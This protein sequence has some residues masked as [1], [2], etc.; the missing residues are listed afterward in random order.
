M[1]VMIPAIIGVGHSV[2]PAFSDLTNNSW[3]GFGVGKAYSGTSSEIG[4]CFTTLPS[5]AANYFVTG[6]SF[7]LDAP[8]GNP[9]GGVVEAIFYSQT[10]GSV[11]SSSCTPS[12]S[13]FEITAKQS[14]TLNAG[15]LNFTFP[16]P[17]AISAGQVYAI[18][19]RLTACTFCGNHIPLHPFTDYWTVATDNGNGPAGSELV[20]CCAGGPGIWSQQPAASGV[21]ADMSV[22][23]VINSP[24]SGSVTAATGTMA[25]VTVGFFAVSAKSYNEGDTD[26]AKKLAVV[27][28]ASGVA[29]VI[30]IAGGL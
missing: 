5:L 28:V 26:S 9:A 8:N 22:S 3:A 18:T 2:D 25:V 21:V 23:G 7:I 20:S 24:P 13:P 6:A 10:S 19:L 27:A 11:S 15:M 29:V 17:I 1:V 4:D 14:L 16:N 12:G 30:L